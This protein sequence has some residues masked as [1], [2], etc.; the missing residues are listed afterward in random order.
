MAQEGEKTQGYVGDARLNLGLPHHPKTRKLQRRLGPS[1][2]WALV[3]LILWAGH[4]RPN[5]DLAGMDDEDI[6]LACDW[7]GEPGEFV[8][9]AAEVGF[10]D[11]LNDHYVLHDWYEHQPWIAG[12]EQ[13]RK[14]AQKAAYAKHHGREA[15]E[16]MRSASSE[17]AESMRAACGEHAGGMRAACGE[18][19]GG[20]RG[21]SDLDAE[22]CGEHAEGTNPHCGSHAPSPSPT[23]TPSDPRQ[24]GTAPEVD[25]EEDARAG[26]AEEVASW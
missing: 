24:E 23:P 20:M 9:V 3:C 11:V 25:R 14:R 15:A 2:P 17:H 13:R 4:H 5:G 12:R 22:I 6:E 18:H 10:L 21:A 19:A 26:S 8:R 16:S 1:G 7:H